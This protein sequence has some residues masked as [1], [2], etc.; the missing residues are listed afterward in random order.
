MA[1][2]PSTTEYVDTSS[3][4]VIEVSETARLAAHLPPRRAMA[5]NYL[6]NPSGQLPDY[7]SR[8]FN[9]TSSQLSALL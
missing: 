5:A 2:N 6:A 4:A 7:L 1:M 9:E 3:P 8:F